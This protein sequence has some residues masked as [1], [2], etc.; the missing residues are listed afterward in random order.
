MLKLLLRYWTK[1]HK[2][3]GNTEGKKQQEQS[4]VRFGVV[5]GSVY[6]HVVKLA[7]QGQ[8]SRRNLHITRVD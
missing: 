6:E 7:Q 2:K 4:L 5:S 3:T 8:N 1:E